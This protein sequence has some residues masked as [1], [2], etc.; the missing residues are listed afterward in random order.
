M[1][2]YLASPQ[3]LFCEILLHGFYFL[4]RS[5]VSVPPSYS[6]PF[7]FN[8]SF[9]LSLWR[10]YSKA[11]IPFGLQLLGCCLHY[12]L[13]Q[14]S[15]KKVHTEQAL[16]LHPFPYSIIHSRYS[17]KHDGFE[18]IDIE[19]IQY[20]FRVGRVRVD[21][22]ETHAHPPLGTTWVFI[23]HLQCCCSCHRLRGRPPQALPDY[24]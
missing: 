7:P 1:H 5:L 18:T 16:S 3:H 24:V 12:S 15:P 13:V 19:F 14:S 8:F 2:T 22:F 21:L 23:H 4:F 20:L 11:H 17:C 6:L 10:D 9:L